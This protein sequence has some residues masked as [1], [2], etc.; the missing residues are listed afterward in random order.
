MNIALHHWRISQSISI[1]V[2]HIEL[3]HRIAQRRDTT[4]RA[5]S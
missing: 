1:V 4:I 2:P 5:G 3:R